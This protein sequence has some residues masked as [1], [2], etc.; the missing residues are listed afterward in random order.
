MNELISMEESNPKEHVS[1]KP[2]KLFTWDKKELM[3]GFIVIFLMIAV[4]NAG[5][6][7]TMQIVQYV[8]ATCPGAQIASVSPY[9]ISFVNATSVPVIP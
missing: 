8:N 1:N 6:I 2:K 7:A 4:F 9:G 3:Y 5:Q